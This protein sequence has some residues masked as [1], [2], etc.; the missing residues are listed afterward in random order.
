MVEG[1]L[2]LSSGHGGHAGLV[3][4]GQAQLFGSEQGFLTS[5]PNQAQPETPSAASIPIARPVL[6]LTALRLRLVIGVRQ[7]G[8]WISSSDGSL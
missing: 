7:E 5:D 8:F 2:P 4:V 6:T 1:L 3:D